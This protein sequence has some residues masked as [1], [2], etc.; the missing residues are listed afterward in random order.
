LKCSQLFCGKH[1]DVVAGTGTM[2]IPLPERHARPW[3]EHEAFLSAQ[4]NSHYSPDLVTS[5]WFSKAM[6]DTYRLMVGEGK[7]YRCQI[8][9]Y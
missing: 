8:Y 2:V 6:F 7:S 3:V 1:P 5:V 9:R 4:G